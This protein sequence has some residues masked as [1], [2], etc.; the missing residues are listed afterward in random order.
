MHNEEL[1]NLILMR[2]IEGK[3]DREKQCIT[4]LVYVSKLIAKQDL[5][6]IAERQSLLRATRDKKLC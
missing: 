2:Q 1:E 3:R 4:Y 6:E 5:G